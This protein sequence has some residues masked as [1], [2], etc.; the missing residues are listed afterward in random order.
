MVEEFT[1][2]GGLAADSFA[3]WAER[4]SRVQVVPVITAAAPIT[5]F[6]MR[7]VRR[8]MVAGRFGSAGGSGNNPSL[9][10]ECGV[11]MILVFTFC[12]LRSAIFR[13]VG[14][15]LNLVVREFSA[16]LI[17]FTL[18]PVD[19]AFR[20]FGPDVSGVGFVGIDV[21]G[22]LVTGIDAHQHIAEYQ[23]AISR[24]PHPHG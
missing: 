18:N 19:V 7:N 8:S 10:V 11:L 20:A 13:S 12:G 17:S 4:A 15:R 24:Y 5:A 2:G 3:A 22:Q 6:R 14:C 16:G 1:G 23:L 9:L 21:H